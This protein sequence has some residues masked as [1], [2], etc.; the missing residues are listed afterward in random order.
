MTLPPADIPPPVAPVVPRPPAD[1][2]APAVQTMPPALA[3]RTFQAAMQFAHFLEGNLAKSGTLPSNREE[4]QKALNALAHELA[5]AGYPASVAQRTILETA[6]QG[7]IKAGY[8][9]NSNY[10]LLG[11]VTQAI[12]EMAATAMRGYRTGKTPEVQGPPSPAQQRSQ[13]SFGG[14]TP[15]GFSPG[16]RPEAM[17]PGPTELGSPPPLPPWG[18]QDPNRIGAPGIPSTLGLPADPDA[19]M[20]AYEA[21]HG[22]QQA[23]LLDLLLARG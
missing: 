15:A 4:G 20:K 16:A 9:P 18:L 22:D 17:E 7:S 2:P 5:R 1:I 21:Q 6:T 8:G 19:F 3:A 14:F 11:H 12:N 13:G 10:N 23:S